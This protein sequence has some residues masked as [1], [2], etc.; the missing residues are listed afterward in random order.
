MIL[1]SHALNIIN[2]YR[3]HPEVESRKS[4]FSKRSN[5]EVNVQLKILAGMAHIPIKLTC[6]IGLHSFRQLLAEAG[7]ADISVITL[8]MV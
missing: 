6:H 7:I 8:M 3:N 2:V 1:T 5:K 4:L